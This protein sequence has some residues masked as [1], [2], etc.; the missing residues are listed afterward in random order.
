MI[1]CSVCGAPNDD[2]ALLC[3]ECRSFLQGRVDAIDLFST[4]W[5]LMEAPRRTLKKIA[6][7]RHKNYAVILS[8]LFGVAL[9]LAA[10]WWTT[11]LRRYDHP[12]VLAGLSMPG[13]FV[14]GILWTSVTAGGM[15]LLTRTGRKKFSPAFAVTAYASVPVVLSLLLVF[16]VELAV[17]GLDL[18]R[19]NPHP[20]VIDPVAY[21]ALMFL[22]GLA[23]LWSVILLLLGVQVI[24]GVP[25]GRALVVVVILLLPVAG[26][27]MLLAGM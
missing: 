1:H 23:V 15:L 17:F 20:M 5:G 18:F 12:G 16:P 2:L 6:L 11:A 3:G 22:D 24:T 26:A 14:V 13:G 8:A 7:A 25:R 9:V 27:A 4:V 21:V 19:A 10:F